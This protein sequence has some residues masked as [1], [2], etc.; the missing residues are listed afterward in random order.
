MKLKE[1]LL[2]DLARFYALCGIEKNVTGFALL[3]S[4]INPRFLPVIL[5]RCG[6]KCYEGNFKRI[7]KLIT[8]INFFLFKI[9]ITSQVKIGKGLFLPHTCGSVI[10]AA[11][12]GENVT[13]FQNVT[14][15]AKEADMSFDLSLRP[16]VGDNV[17]IGAGA[18]ILGGIKI[19][20]RVTIG[21]NAVV[22][23]D[24][25]DD[26]VAVGVPAKIERKNHNG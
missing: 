16:I 12:I 22:L 13:I 4:C 9:E 2:Y 21:A 26:H 5:C 18:K 3:K 11:E 20:N 15:G 23:K 7:A 17:T 14:L 1:Y 25:P 24:V 6:R 19:G 8:W 10:G